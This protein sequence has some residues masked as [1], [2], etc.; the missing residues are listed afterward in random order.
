MSRFP[1][2]ADSQP[3]KLAAVYAVFGVLWILTTDRLVVALVSDPARVTALQTVK[4]WLFVALSA[5]LVYTLVVTGQHDLRRTNRRLDDA[6]Q[7]TSILDRILRHNLRN[8]CNV[9]QA[10]AA[11]LEDERELSEEQ[12]QCLDR[13]ET[14]NETL[15]ELGEKSRELRDIVLAEPPGRQEV[16][17]VDAVEAGVE[18]VETA[19]PHAEIRA[20]LPE[21]L[22]IRADPRIDRAVY[23]LL[24]NAVVH[25][26]SPDP[27]VEVTASDRGGEVAVEIADDGPGLPEIERKVLGQ[28]IETQMTHSEGLGLWIARALVVRHGGEFSVSND[29][30]RG[31]TVRCVLPYDE[32]KERGTFASNVYADS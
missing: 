21:S 1:N 11:M 27:T 2:A 26:D 18:A 3:L 20:T 23:E 16:D 15:I 10:N 29:E 12:E 9:I 31:T 19:H 4:G 17:L 5:L 14:H 22:R 7:Q 8:S 28:G 32:A 6:L 25:N 24:E 30:P 13:I